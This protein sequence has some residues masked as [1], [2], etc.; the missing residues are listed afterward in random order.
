M[1]TGLNDKWLEAEDFSN[2]DTWTSYT[3]TIAGVLPAG[4]ETYR[5]GTPSKMALQFEK[6]DKILGLNVTNYRILK[7]LLGSNP[8]KWPGGRVA[9]EPRMFRGEP[10]V[11]VSAPVNL[12]KSVA[13]FYGTE[14]AGKKVITQD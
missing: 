14:L 8:N 10:C 4:A 12:R 11:R 3:L 9:F 7:L 13:K 6:T 5:D 1:D 2:G